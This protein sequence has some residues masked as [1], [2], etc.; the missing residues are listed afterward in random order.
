MADMD[1]EPR[2]EW[3][4]KQGYSVVGTDPGIG[5]GGLLSQVGVRYGPQRA[6]W[7]GRKDKKTTHINIRAKRL[8]HILYVRCNI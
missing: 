8:W 6:L 5:E 7:Y 2:T 4:Y 1:F 3:L